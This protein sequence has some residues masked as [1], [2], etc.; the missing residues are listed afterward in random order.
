MGSGLPKHVRWQLRHS[1]ES[2]AGQHTATFELAALSASWRRHTAAQRMSPATL[3]T[4]SSLTYWD[5]VHQSTSSS[6]SPRTSLSGL[7]LEGFQGLEDECKPDCMGRMLRER[8][9]R[10]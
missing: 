8:S 5:A 4:Y 6:V 7:A 3:W 9:P 1:P 10:R 2:R